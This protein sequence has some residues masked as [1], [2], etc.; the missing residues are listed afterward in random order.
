MKWH[1]VAEKMYNGRLHNLYSSQSI[2]KIKRT[3]NDDMGKAF[4]MIE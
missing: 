3:K 1:V 2:I 4:S